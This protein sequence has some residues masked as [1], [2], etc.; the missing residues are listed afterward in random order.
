M[1]AVD[2]VIEAML[3]RE[4]ERLIERIAGWEQRAC[5]A[6]W[7]GGSPSPPICPQGVADGTLIES[8][9]V[10]AGEGAYLR[11]DQV[12]E[13]A[14]LPDGWGLYTVRAV[15]PDPDSANVEYVVLF[16]APPGDGTSLLTTSVTVTVGGVTRISV[17]DFS[18]GLVEVWSTLGATTAGTGGFLPH[19]TTI[20]DNWLRAASARRTGLE[21]LDTLI[22]TV[23]SRDTTRI[24]AHTTFVE[25]ECTTSLG[26]GFRPRCDDLGVPPGTI[27]EV[28]PAAA[29]EGFGILR[30]NF[31]Q[32]MSILLGEELTFW[33][34]YQAARP[35]SSELERP[36]YVLV[37]LSVGPGRNYHGS[38]SQLH[39]KS[40]QLIFLEASFSSTLPR[41]EE[42][43]RWLIRP[44]PLA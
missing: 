2:F 15:R 21:E 38:S 39:I 33:A 31:E 18:D 19:A 34:A 3:A 42:I 36:D 8:F 37:F 41:E 44:V 4:P 11:R 17:G 6:D 22:E 35:A 10:V 14:R 29:Q 30:A 40:G 27:V 25:M 13:F 43:A 9:F 16:G 24:A 1:E 20:A 7:S 12:A 26:I 23:L 28:L 32:T 5:V